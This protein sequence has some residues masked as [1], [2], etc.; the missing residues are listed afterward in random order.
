MSLLFVLA[1]ALE[2]VQCDFYTPFTCVGRSV[3][4]P[5]SLVDYY[6]TIIYFT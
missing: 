1:F 3:Y 2:N 5:K 4:L 6:I